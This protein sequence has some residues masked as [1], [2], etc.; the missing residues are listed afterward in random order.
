MMSWHALG[1][2]LGQCLQ[3]VKDGKSGLFTEYSVLRTQVPVV[4][5]NR[6]TDRHFYITKSFAIL[7][8]N[9]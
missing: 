8:Q 1:P 5:E 9:E 6:A 2:D 3:A 4:A 7:G